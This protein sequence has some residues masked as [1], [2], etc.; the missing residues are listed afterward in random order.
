MSNVSPWLELDELEVTWTKGGQVI[1]QDQVETM[2]VGNLIA[3]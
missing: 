1:P 2:G 3:R